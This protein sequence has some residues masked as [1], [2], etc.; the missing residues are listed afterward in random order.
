MDIVKDYLDILQNIENAILDVFETTPELRD[1]DIILALERL[2][3][4]Y[5]R[6]KKKLPTLPVALPERSMLIFNAVRAACELRLDRTAL[7]EIEDHEFAY[8]VPLRLLIPCIDRV[9]K[10]AHT[11]HK[12]DGQ[13]GYL[14]FIG[15]FL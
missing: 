10:S 6:E 14:Q 15:K 11:W 9:L 12:R 13:R 7:V 4:Q 5:T 8:R 3:S 2:A 1:P